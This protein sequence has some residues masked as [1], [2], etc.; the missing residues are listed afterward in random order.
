M[1]VSSR[2]QDTAGVVLD[3]TISTLTTNLGNQTVGTAQYNA[4]AA[5]LA[6]TQRQQID[7]HVAQSGRLTAANILLTTLHGSAGNLPL[8]VPQSDVAFQQAFAAAAAFGGGPVTFTGA[9]NGAASGTLSASVTNGKYLALFADGE[10]RVVSVATGTAATWTTNLLAAG[11]GVPSIT[12]ATILW[13]GTATGQLNFT[14]VTIGVPAFGQL[15]QFQADNFRQRY[16]QALREL[17]NQALNKGYTT[18]AN[19][20]ASSL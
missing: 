7:R 2:A 10:T 18:S 19:I 5:A 6:Q 16:E 17:L 9:V 4:T 11:N 8:Q 20:L 13:L 14:L 12:T 1:T 3:A 15:P